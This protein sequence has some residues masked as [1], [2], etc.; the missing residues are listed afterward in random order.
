MFVNRFLHRRRDKCGSDPS[1][2]SRDLDLLAGEG[3]RRRRSWIVTGLFL[4]EYETKSRERVGGG[5]WLVVRARRDADL[6]RVRGFE[7][8]MVV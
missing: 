4:G 3:E 8:W 2:S 6:V 5:S 7:W 1:S